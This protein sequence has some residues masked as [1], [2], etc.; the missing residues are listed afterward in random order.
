MIRASFHDAESL[1]VANQVRGLVCEPFDALRVR[2]CCQPQ[3]RPPTLDVF[4]RTTLSHTHSMSR[5]P[6]LAL[7]ASFR[8]PSSLSL[9]VSPYTPMRSLF[10]TSPSLLLLA[11][12]TLVSTQTLIPL[13]GEPLEGARLALFGKYSPL[14]PIKPSFF[15]SHG[16]LS[17]FI[18]VSHSSAPLT[19]YRLRA[20]CAFAHANPDGSFLKRFLLLLFLLTTLFGPCSQ[21]A[22]VFAAVAGDQAALLQVVSQRLGSHAAGPADRTK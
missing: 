19:H 17:F 11:S 3:T 13:P 14:L 21:L 15:P 4:S 2:S 10:L 1:C 5:A 7:R 9:L 20:N 12:S 16:L 8:V 22:I 18:D 6:F